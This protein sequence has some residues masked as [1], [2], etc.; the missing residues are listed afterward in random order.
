LEEEEFKDF[1]GDDQAGRV[2]QELTRLENG[3]EA[4]QEAQH[5]GFGETPDQVL[6]ILKLVPQ[7]GVFRGLTI[8]Q[9]EDRD[10]VSFIPSLRFVL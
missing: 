1:G 7:Q 3:G 5:K 2:D 4:D 6:A 10:D 9:L 8:E